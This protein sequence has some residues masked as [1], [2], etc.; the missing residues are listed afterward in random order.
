MYK[1]TTKR[2]FMKSIESRRKNE[3]INFMQQKYYKRCQSLIEYLYLRKKA[4]L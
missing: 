3:I 4:E 2:E 1:Q